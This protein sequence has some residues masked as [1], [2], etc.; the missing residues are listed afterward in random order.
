MKIKTHQVHSITDKGQII[1]KARFKTTKHRDF[2]AG[3]FGKPSK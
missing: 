3:A 2:Q 1:W